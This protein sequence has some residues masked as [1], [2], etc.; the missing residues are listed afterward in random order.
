MKSAAPKNKK[1]THKWLKRISIAVGILF[2][3][4]LAL[5][6]I[7]WANRN[8]IIDGLQEWYKTNHNGSLEIGRVD[9]NFL[10][11]F[12]NIGFTINDV[13]QIDFDT[14]LDKS[15]SISIDR[16]WV[17]IG[18]QDLLK[19]DIQFK[20]ILIQKAEIFSEVKTTKTPEQY[21]QLKKKSQED[22]QVGIQLPPWL[23]P[24][25]TEFSL[26][27]IKFIS[28]DT[29]LNKYFNLEA[30]EVEGTI[31]SNENRSYG[32]LNFKVLV[33]DLGFN[34]KKGAYIN[35]AVVSGDP[36][37]VLDKKNNS[38]VLSEFILKVDDQKFKANAD[39]DFSGHTTYQ[40]SFENP[41]T[42]FRAI[43][44][45][46]PQQLSE[47]ISTYQISEPI[48][49]SLRLKGKFLYGAVPFIHG[50]FSTQANRMAINDSTWL[51]HVKFDGYLTND[52]NKG[53]NKPRH[54]AS[55]KDI[56]I[57]FDDFAAD[58][59]DIKISARESYFQSSDTASNFVN[60]HLKMYGPNET[61]AEVMQNNNF[62][63]EGGN[64]NFAANINGDISESEN[65]LNSATGRFTLRNTRV[66][67]KRNQLQLPLEIADLSLNKEISILN[68]L[69]VNLPDGHDL[70]LSGT[71]TNV[72]S[73][74]SN[75]PEDPAQASL[76]LDSQDLNLNEL[77]AAATASVPKNEKKTSNLTTLHEIFKAVYTKFRPQIKLDLNSLEYNGLTFKDIAAEMR[78]SNPETL[79]FDH[80]NFRY[81]EA[82]TQL[83]GTLRVPEQD[84]ENKE[85][86][87]LYF[88]TRSSG[89]ISIF[90][91]LFK[92]S[93]MN[94]NAGEYVFSGKIAGNIQKLEEVL[95]NIEG[96]LRL[97]DAQFYYSNAQSLIEFDSLKVAVNHS[98][99]NIDRFEIEV[100][101][102]HP[103]SLTGEIKDFPGFLV[104]DIK[105]N[106]SLSIKLDAAYVDMDEWMETI[107]AI[108]NDKPQQKVKEEKEADLNSVF[109]D[110]YKFHPKFSL[111]VDSLKFRDLITK[112]IGGSVYFE[113]DN[114]LKLDD[115]DFEY[116]D[117]KAR[118]NG[119]LTA[120]NTDETIGENPF[121]FDFSAEMK[122]KNRDLNDF[123]RTVNFVF[124]SGDFEFTASYQG[125]AKDLNILNS[126]FEGELMLGRSIVDIKAADLLVP[127]DSL[128]LKI[129]NDLANLDRLDI[130][131]PGKSSLDITGAINNF[132]SFINNDQAA[133]SHIS[134]F[135]IKSAY[136]NNKDIKTFLK[137]SNKKRDTTTTKDFKLE[138]LKEVLDNI[139]TSY[140][141]SVNVEID[142]L[143]FG[144][145]AVSNFGSQ[146]GYKNNGEF[147]IEDTQLQ[148]LGGRIDLS[149]E[150]GVQT[151]NDLPVT[152]NM[153]AEDIDLQKLVK[154]LNYFGSEE[155]RKADKI[156]GTLNFVL[157]ASGVMNNDG[158]LDMNSLNGTLQLDLE[159][160]ALYNFKP[161]TENT[162]LMKNERFEHL[163]FRPI[164]QT[165]K[166]KD[167]KIIIPRTQIQSSALQV[168]VQG[169]LR[170]GE[171]VNI[172][173]SLPWHNLKSISGLELPEK[174][175]FDEAGSKFYI[176]II[177]D[178]NS[179]KSSRQKL[180]TKF[181]L[182]N[183]KMKKSLDGN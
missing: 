153:N 61:L 127:V 97:T 25:K 22:P 3:V 41:E 180:K 21:I 137:S 56:K 30:Q 183:A 164:K 113:N 129:K 106:G 37:F 143:I 40:L 141:P 77:I 73:L 178:K 46:L 10:S 162:P 168:F 170:I 165:F 78:L 42:D 135:T 23:H 32:R 96:D 111:A 159:E 128:H 63:F 26:H 74:L 176:Q 38:L 39:F 66:I 9:A 7:G 8:L 6:V 148:Y 126:D 68:S 82:V 64:F 150:A 125:E 158:S 20:K 167:G 35:G 17:S 16:A 87:Y 12:P 179:E 146:I 43:K 169:E 171:Y 99:V 144:N 45:I 166:V 47:K 89:P 44:K 31:F 121:D 28:K 34:T 151:T 109:N 83:D 50:T 157:D 108:D 48:T 91:D 11:G 13:R 1:T 134:Y 130:D 105:S 177:Q 72:A 172:W 123:L 51:D 2:L 57:M 5:F 147:K 85:P 131:L 152:V 132:S 53:E 71:L 136:L 139:H 18:A 27:D 124:Q 107:D 65:L 52:L 142:S 98:N 138:N 49:T 54:Q 175:S 69:K 33:N 14:I 163:E 104:D 15:S 60:A 112:N 160:L 81:K 75:D 122:G 114:V 88:E 19:G 154:D 80:F 119:T 36:K 115:L 86:V 62:S 116:G 117:S 84:R 67:L 103:F 94:I 58:L 145:I 140:Y 161:V 95:N 90:Q 156:D 101:G 76:K 100:G 182:G 92:I 174:T 29:V 155:L 173:L 118:I 120:I 181:R 133:D 24:E 79:L 149:L 110:I 102:H 55:K 93:L 59:K 70:E 4:P